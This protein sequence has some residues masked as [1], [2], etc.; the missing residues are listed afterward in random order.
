[1]FGFGF[2]NGQVSYKYEVQDSLYAGKPLD[3]HQKEILT[4]LTITKIGAMVSGVL[5]SILMFLR[6]NEPDFNGWV[7]YQ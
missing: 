3:Q 4:D 5:C 2:I 6:L 1:L 7:T